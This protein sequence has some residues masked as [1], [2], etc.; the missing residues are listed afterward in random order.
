L[1]VSILAYMPFSNLG[2]F[3]LPAKLVKAT[4]KNANAKIIFFIIKLVK[5]YRLIDLS[6]DVKVKF[7]N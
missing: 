4:S 3:G 7:K 2:F 6:K 5:I 1:L